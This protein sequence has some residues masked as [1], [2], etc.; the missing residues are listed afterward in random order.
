MERVMTLLSLLLTGIVLLV[1]VA[2]CIIAA[3]V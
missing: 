2:G 1:I 3:L